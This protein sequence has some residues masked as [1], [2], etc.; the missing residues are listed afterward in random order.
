MTLQSISQKLEVI[1][2]PQKLKPRTVFNH[3][4]DTLGIYSKISIIRISITRTL[5]NPINTGPFGG[6]SV[7]GRGGGGWFAPPL[8]NFFISYAFALKL[9]TGV[10]QRLM[11]T[12]LRKKI[13]WHQHFFYDVIF[14]K[15]PK[16]FLK[17][18]FFNFF[19]QYIESKIY[20]KKSF[21]KNIF[22]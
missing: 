16:F 2:V 14:P 22:F 1:H 17:N 15:G 9:V 7:P 8:H 19:L 6:S 5:L 4:K 21:K 10:H 3:K 11:N 20:H 12:L 13:W 18:F